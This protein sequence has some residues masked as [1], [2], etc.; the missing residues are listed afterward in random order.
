MAIYGLNPTPGQQNPMQPVM[1]LS[2]RLLQVRSVK[3]GE[4]VGYG[5]THRFESDGKVGTVALGYADGFLRSAGNRAKLYYN[6]NACPLVGRVSMD[7][8]TVDLGTTDAKPG[9]RLEVLGPHQDADA[10][11]SD[12]GTIGYEVLTG[13][14]SR[15]GR[16]YSGIL[17]KK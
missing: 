13:L 10:L 17:I 12:M 15:W 14:G 5:A 9:D 8:V 4:T 6:G 1:S 3:K 7:L 2:T 16:Q 11:A